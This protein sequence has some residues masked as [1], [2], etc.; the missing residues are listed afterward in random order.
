[1]SKGKIER[2]FRTCRGQLLARL[3]DADTAS[4]EAL[5]RRLAGWIEGE[6][7]ASPHR[8]LELQTPLERWAQTGE[9]LRYPEPT[10]DLDDLFLFEEQRSVHND[11]TVSLHG[12]VYEV[13]ATLV[14][15]RVT[16][17]Y[18]PSRPEAPVQVVHQGQV[19][20]QARQVDLYA[21][22]QVKR[23]R[24]TGALTTDDPASPP[25]STLAMRTLDGPAADKGS[26]SGGQG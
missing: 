3:T 15:Q 23:Q 24:R 21:N 10:L 19:I 2:F 18:D 6:Y 4:L 9:R 16:L 8:G 12:R 20:E 13:D 5:N 14:G 22:C 7:H 25:A 1:V 26:T 17:R 11:R